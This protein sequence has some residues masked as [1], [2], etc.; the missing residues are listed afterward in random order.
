MELQT[1]CFFLCLSTCGTRHNRWLWFN[2]CRCGELGHIK[3]AWWRLIA[4]AMNIFLLDRGC[5]W[6]THQDAMCGCSHSH[7]HPLTFLNHVL[8][9]SW[10][11]GLCR[12]LW[13]YPMSMGPSTVPRSMLSCACDDCEVDHRCF[14]AVL[15]SGGGNTKGTCWSHFIEFIQ[16]LYYQWWISIISLLKSCY[17]VYSQ[18]LW[19]KNS[20]SDD[21]VTP[22]FLHF[23]SF[24]EA[25]LENAFVF[26]VWALV[27]L[28]PIAS[29][30]GLV[31]IFF[32]FGCVHFCGLD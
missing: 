25:S 23:F 22:M 32:L 9:A 13:T 28:L 27:V 1:S 30:I 10:I 19:N 31:R 11:R 5:W 18:F 16:W 24:L 21:Q 14:A 2:A 3:S 6:W 26:R 20:W 15:A 7:R 12:G 4:C 8:V 17:R 29:P